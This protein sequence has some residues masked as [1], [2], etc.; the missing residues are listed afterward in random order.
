M[1]GISI[2][3]SCPCAWGDEEELL[4]PPTTIHHYCTP[5]SLE[6]RKN[7]FLL[8][9]SK[10]LPAAINSICS[11]LLFLAGPHNN[12]IDRYTDRREVFL[13]RLFLYFTATIYTHQ[14]VLLAGNLTCSI[15]REEK[16]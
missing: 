2:T 8:M 5:A 14:V 3:V 7:V 6:N 1:N 11:F 12:K 16:R 9:V 4:L 10:S 15:I 13:N